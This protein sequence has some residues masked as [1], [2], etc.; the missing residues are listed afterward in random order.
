LLREV[1]CGLFVAVVKAETKEIRF[2]DFFAS[3][4]SSPFPSIFVSYLVLGGK[5]RGRGQ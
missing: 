5:T 3:L 2:G 1:G 4:S